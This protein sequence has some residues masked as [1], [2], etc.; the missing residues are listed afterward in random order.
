MSEEKRNTKLE[1][2]TNYLG[3]LTD[4]RDTGWYSYDGV[5]WEC[6]WKEGG[7]PYTKEEIDA[8]E[9]PEYR[10]H[11]HCSTKI[12]KNCLLF[13]INT[14]KAE[15]VGSDC[16]KYFNGHLKRCRGCDKIYRGNYAKCKEC[17][18]EEEEEIWMKKEREREIRMKEER[19]ER[20]KRVREQESTIIPLG[21]YR[22][23]HIDK[24][25]G[26]DDDYIHWLL[27]SSVSERMKTYIWKDIL[28]RTKMQ[29]GKHRNKTIEWVCVN[30]R[31]YY[32]W[33]VR[34]MSFM[35]TKPRN[36]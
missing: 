16:I 26:H 19:E 10:S 17:R 15:I 8:M 27:T 20:E 35:R 9:K 32:A 3:D 21:K 36:L 30:D 1:K 12:A 29:H 2:L 33:M 31:G 18:D 14:N 6:R 13:N 5:D 28:F 34:S 24:L 23:M 11:C 25:L 4:Y 7:R 22:G